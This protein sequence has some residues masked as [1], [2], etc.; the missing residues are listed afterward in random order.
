M[1]V[2]WWVS[3]LATIPF[4]VAAILSFQVRAGVCV[5]ILPRIDSCFFRQAVFVYLVDYLRPVAAS[6]MAA[7]SAMRSVF[8]GGALRVMWMCHCVELIRVLRDDAQ[9]SLS[10][11]V[12]PRPARAVSAPHADIHG[13]LRSSSIRR[14]VQQARHTMGIGPLRVPA[15]CDHSVS[16]PSTTWPRLRLRADQRATPQLPISI[17]FLWQVSRSFHHICRSLTGIFLL[18]PATTSIEIRSDGM[19]GLCEVLLE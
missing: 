7:N 19:K 2:P 12:S 4:G 18:Q 13:P 5:Y 16:P 14:H 8:G 11:R 15:G 1:S 17:L 3:Q 9:L 6:A 10:S